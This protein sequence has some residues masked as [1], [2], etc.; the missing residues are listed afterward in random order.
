MV[1]NILSLISGL[2]WVAGKLFEFLYARQMVNVGQTQQQLETLRKEIHDAQIAI[3]ARE[4][5]RISILKQPDR[6]VPA[7]DPF[8]RD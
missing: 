6:I 1:A 2:I 5:V 3:A 7:D 8:L 4:A